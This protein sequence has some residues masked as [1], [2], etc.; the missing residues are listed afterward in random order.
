MV[1]IVHLFSEYSLGCVELPSGGDCHCHGRLTRLSLDS[2]F[3]SAK[4]NSSHPLVDL[5][6]SLILSIHMTFILSYPSFH[7]HYL[8]FLIFL[9]K[10]MVYFYDII[11][12]Q[13][14]QLTTV[15][16]AGLWSASLVLAFN[17][18]DHASRY[19]VWFPPD[20]N[21]RPGFS[22]LSGISGWSA[23]VGVS[24]G[25]GHVMAYVAIGLR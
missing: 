9:P 14:E 5:I 2:F 19:L 12:K 20:S 25:V 17:P 8:T 15:I 18:N 11:K 24:M 1:A 10:T 21:P 13:R 7:V 3:I 4:S 16:G 22:A 23:G 6:F